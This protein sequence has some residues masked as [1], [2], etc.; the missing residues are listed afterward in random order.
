[1]YLVEYA[2]AFAIL[3]G[4]E[5]KKDLIEYDRPP[6]AIYLLI[7]NK[8]PQHRYL[9]RIQKGQWLMRDDYYNFT[10]I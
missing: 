6:K 3:N 8:Q 9:I 5:L 10:D 4:E 2:H 1:M 7:E